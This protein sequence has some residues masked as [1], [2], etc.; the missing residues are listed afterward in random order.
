MTDPYIGQLEIFGFSFAP[1]QWAFAAGQMVSIQQNSALYS[2]I[3]TTFGG[4]GTSTFQLP[5]LAARQA[6]GSGQGPGLSDRSMGEPF[7]D[8]GVTL[9]IGEMP[10]H[11]H[12]MNTYYPDGAETVLPANNS[13][14]S[15][16]ETGN[17]Y[18]YAPPPGTPAAFNPQF[19]QPAGAGQPHDNLQPYL[20]L[21][22]S[23]ALQGVFPTFG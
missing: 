7:G 15:F 10:A 4:N 13:G 16:V 19:V 5:N 9:G 23:I 2:L 6:C 22:Y 20:G 12:G 3:G 18:A 1:Y 21:N 8:A 14:I 11:N 17:F